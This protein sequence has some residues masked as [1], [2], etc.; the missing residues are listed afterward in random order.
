MMDPKMAIHI[1][2]CGGWWDSLPD[3][4]SDADMNPLQDAIDTAV[5]VLR[6]KKCQ[7]IHLPD[8][9]STKADRIRAMAD[10]EL[11]EYL[12][13]LTY[14]CECKHRNNCDGNNGYLKW[15][16]QPAEEGC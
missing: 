12:C 15:L 8:V 1:L 16:Q 11:A 9:P 3:G 7:K 2:E 5:A 4:I 13:G 10:N 14:C 6:E